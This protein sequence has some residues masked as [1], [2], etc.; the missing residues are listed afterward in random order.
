M[1][2]PIHDVWLSLGSNLGDRY[3]HLMGGLAFLLANG[4]ELRNCSGIYETEPVGY[5]EQPSFYNMAVH[6]RTSLEPLA[7]LEICRQAEKAYKRQRT[8]RWGPRTLDVDILLIDDLII[9]WPELTVPH[10]RMAER[11]FVLGP[12]GEMDRDLLAKWNLPWIHEGIVLKIA[13][14]DVKMNITGEI[15]GQGKDI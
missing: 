13:A 15:E 5:T 4:L 8:L 12:L 2:E 6:C 9:D 14:A 1:S 3:E 10:P 7:L 11:A